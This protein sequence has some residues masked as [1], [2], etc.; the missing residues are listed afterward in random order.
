MTDVCR[1]ALVA[2]GA[3][4]ASTGASAASDPTGVWFND[5][6]RGAIEIKSC[7]DKLCGHVVWVKD[8]SDAKGCGKQIIGEARSVGGNRWDNGW[9]YS[10]EK[11]RKYDV[12]LTPLDNGKLRVTGYAGVKFLSKTMIWTKAPDDLKR[13]DSIEARTEP[14]PAA[15]PAATASA[16]T[17]TNEIAKSAPAAET[18][19]NSKSLTGMLNALDRP[20]PR[21]AAP[22]PNPAP[23]ATPADTA[24]PAEAA[25]PEAAPAAEEG[26]KPEG[27]SQQANADDSSGSE[28][29]LDL[30][31][32]N[33][34]K[35]LQKSADGKCKLD[36]PWVKVKFD[37]SRFEDKIR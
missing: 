24:K 34:E 27:E 30:G 3:A 19:R 29:G 10:P 28:D 11:K 7:G 21:A 14:A 35:F 37:C 1:L 16:K 32:L 20:A 12:E 17:E 25:T 15:A 18:A 36:L 2:L 33:I 22:E 26:A 13:C 9:I 5:T 6:G 8:G 31:G 4:A 23:A